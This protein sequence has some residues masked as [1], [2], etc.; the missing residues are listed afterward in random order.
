MMMMFSDKIITLQW[1]FYSSIYA[2][3]TPAF[4]RRYLST[5]SERGAT[6][7]QS[8]GVRCYV[9]SGPDDVDGGSPVL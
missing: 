7:D 4:F 2:A 6:S 9:Y 1:C 5:N 3:H 8:S